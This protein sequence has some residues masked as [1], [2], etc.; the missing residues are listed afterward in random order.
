MSEINRYLVYEHLWYYDVYQKVI[1]YTEELFEAVRIVECL[2]ACNKG[3]FVCEYNFKKLYDDV[4]EKNDCYP[5]A[6]WVNKFN[7]HPRGECMS[8]VDVIDCINYEDFLAKY[9]GGKQ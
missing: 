9:K 2:R 3:N 4:D 7:R 8:K 6:L 1:C 5:S